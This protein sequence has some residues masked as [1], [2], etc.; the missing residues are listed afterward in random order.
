VKISWIEAN[1]LAGSGIPLDAKDIVALHSQGIRAILT[2][3]EQP[4]TAQKQ[5]TPELLAE[6][7]IN[8]MHIAVR[9]QF[10]PDLEQARPIVEYIDAMIAQQ[11]PVL[12][13]CH[14]G[15]GRTG[16]ALH[17]YYV[18]KGDSYEQAKQRIR[19]TRIQSILLSDPQKEFIEQIARDGLPS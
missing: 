12:V 16:T 7:D 11:R 18:A 5:I 19:Q 6:Y 9:D 13:H 14:A 8:A 10:A 1:R 15:V 17:L 2:L 3:T 4:L